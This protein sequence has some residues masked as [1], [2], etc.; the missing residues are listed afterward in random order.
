[1]RVEEGLAVLEVARQEPR[2][3]PP[4][5][6]HPL[7]NPGRHFAAYRLDASRH[8]FPMG[9]LD[10]ADITVVSYG[11]GESW[12][13]TAEILPGGQILRDFLAFSTSAGSA[14]D[15]EGAGEEERGKRLSAACSMAA[16]NAYW[17]D[18]NTV[19]V[20]RIT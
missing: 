12:I 7:P 13:G 1:M 18:K 15:R 19:P 20:L 6:K 11:F 3:T 4:G 17:P 10:R 9:H 16:K 5:S 14:L 2:I 8:V